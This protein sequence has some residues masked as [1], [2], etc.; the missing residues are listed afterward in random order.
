MPRERTGDAA[1]T[2]GRSRCNC[3]TPSGAIAA[4]PRD[5]ETARL[6]VVA[7]MRGR[8]AELRIAGEILGGAERGRGG[9]LLIEGDP[10]IG[11]TGLL[12]EIINE[13]TQ[14]HF[15]VARAEADEIGQRTPFAPLLTALQDAVSDLPGETS[16]LSSP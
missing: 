6:S 5:A 13:A 7:T 14:R 9:V 1:P 10:G 2:R 15:S 8:D 12:G 3:S 4:R 11:K 16:S